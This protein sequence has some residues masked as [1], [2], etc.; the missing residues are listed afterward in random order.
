MAFHLR[1]S[2]I[3]KPNLSATRND[4][5]FIA[6]R[7]S[8][9]QVQLRHRR[10]AQGKHAEGNSLPLYLLLDSIAV[11]RINPPHCQIPSLLPHSTLQQ[12]LPLVSSFLSLK[13]QSCLAR[14]RPF[15]KYV[16]SDSEIDIDG[17][18]GSPLA[19]GAEFGAEEVERVCGVIYETFDVDRNME[20]VLDEC[21]VELSHE[22]VL[23]VLRR[24]RCARKPAFRFFCWASE[25]PGYAHDSATYN[26]MVDVLGKGRQ[27]ES[28][29]SMIEEMGEKGFLSVETFI[30]CIRAF[31]SAK[32]RRKA[33]GVLDLMSKYKFRVGVE[34]INCLLDALGKAGLGKE[35]HE[36]F[37]R[38]EHHFTPDF[39]TY[40]VLL[41]GWCEVR[42]LMEAGRV[43]NGMI[44]GGFKPDVVAHNI[45][46]RGLLRGGKRCDA[47]KLFEVMK[48]K[49]PY[50]NVRTYTILINHLSKHGHMEEALNYMDD[51]HSSGC[52]PDATIYTCLM[53]GF[54]N[55]REMGMVHRLL[56]EMREKGCPPD[57]QAYNGLIKVMTN[58]KMPDDAVTIYK[59]MIQSG[60]QPSIHTYN[61]MMKAYFVASNPEM[62]CAVWDEMKRRGCCP[63]ENSYT[64]LIGGLIRQGRSNEAYEYLEEMVE[65]G[66]KAPQLDYKNIASYFSGRRRNAL[67]EFAEKARFS[68][69]SEVATLFA[70][71]PR[72]LG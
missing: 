14:F 21:G 61:M 26:A 60:I 46:L 13:F 70:N 4:G 67:D 58:Q 31:A 54:G 10:E 66:M 36:L 18:K 47:I 29:V 3:P 40:T 7:S 62:G 20:A 15:C 69:N 32:E 19:E 48:S 16:S 35:A 64:V 53:I 25:Q 72:R 24:F 17:E 8:G 12:S 30:V 55:Q 71:W 2:R 11:S 38:L 68:G 22:L 43:W 44:D 34:A 42:N 9:E 33:F 63:D 57:G 5:L 50:P 51:M 52:E 65:K 49:G 39:K 59:R 27:F 6:S 1:N 28:M 56:K 37:Q 41:N 23:C 45:L